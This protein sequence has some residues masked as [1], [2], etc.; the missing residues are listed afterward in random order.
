MGSGASGVKVTCVESA[1]HAN[2]PLT[3][4]WRHGRSTRPAS[5]AARS[6]GWLNVTTMSLSGSTNMAPSCGVM[7]V[8]AGWMVAKLQ[9]TSAA[10]TPS[11]AAVSPA[12]MRTEYSVLGARSVGMKR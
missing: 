6:I 2:A 4:S 10:R 1:F 11:V 7:A 5:T 12:G 3:G 9:V 8:T